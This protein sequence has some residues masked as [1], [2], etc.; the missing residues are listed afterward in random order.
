MA[1]RR[2]SRKGSRMEGSQASGSSRLISAEAAWPRTLSQDV[3]LC[4]IIVSGGRKE[5]TS[6]SSDSG[7]S[8]ANRPTD[9]PKIENYNK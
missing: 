4:R 8:A 9:C 1:V 5:F 7:N 2:G 3:E 6:V